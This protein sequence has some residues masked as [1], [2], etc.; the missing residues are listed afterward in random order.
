M[1]RT[2][3]IPLLLVRDGCLVKTVRFRRF[4]YVGDPCNTARI[5]NELEVDEL[6][7]VDISKT[8]AERGPDLRLIADLANECFMPLGYGGGVRSLEDARAIFATGVEKV[9]INTAAVARPKLIDEIASIYGSQA[10]IVS[11]DVKREFLRMPTVRTSN[12]RRWTGLDPVTWAKEAARLGAGEIMVTAID[13]EG[14]W[15]GFDINLVRQVAMSV[16]VPVIAHGGAGC[17]RDIRDA[18]ALGGAS[19]VALGSMVM[20]QGRGMG[21]LINFPRGD[22]LAGSLTDSMPTASPNVP[23]HR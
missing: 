21:V 17:L 12:G 9:V 3:V 4:A 16:P 11:I 13:R 23:P 6:L 22:D 5:F 2:R 10:V 18:V 19:A 15:T 20:F 1:L 7:V 8:R 14:T